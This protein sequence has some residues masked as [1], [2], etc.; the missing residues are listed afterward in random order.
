MV[1]GGGLV[2][3]DGIQWQRRRERERIVDVA[4]YADIKAGPIQRHLQVGAT[5]LG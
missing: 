3:D 2:G 5:R 1:Q 4:N